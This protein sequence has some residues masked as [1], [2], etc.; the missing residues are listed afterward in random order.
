MRNLKILGL[1]AM[2]AFFNGCSQIREAGRLGANGSNAS[3]PAA[4]SGG[5]NVPGNLKNAYRDSELTEEGAAVVTLPNNTDI[6]Y[7]KDAQKLSVDDLGKKFDEYYAAA[8]GS[9]AAKAVYI[10][11]DAGNEYG[12]VLKI[13]ELARRKR[14][15]T[16]RL[17]VSQNE[18]GEPADIFQVEFPDNR[19][20]PQQPLKP[21]PNTL[22]ATF[23]KDG[24]YLLNREDK[25]TDELK[26]A[27]SEIFKYRKDN[28]VLREGTNE[29]EQTVTI[30]APR[31]AKYGEV[32]K[33]INIIKE[34]GAN[35]IVIQIDEE[36]ELE[37]VV[38]K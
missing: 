1:C 22:V 10:I 27:L 2:L 23:V 17:V 12:A 35:P 38:I 18:K 14:I 24:I 5:V 15:E 11:A 26:R 32:V 21:N 28:L 33:L 3:P 13:L 16:A 29:V 6:L 36:P 34:T 31:S 37:K 9:K 19:L 4:K 8:G 30:K 20:Q 25:T 7:R